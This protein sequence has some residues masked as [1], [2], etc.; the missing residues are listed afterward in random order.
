MFE[1]QVGR[2][3]ND[4]AG[5]TIE[6]DQGRNGGDLIDGRDHNR[7]PAEVVGPSSEHGACSQIAPGKARFRAKN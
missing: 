4:A 3:E 6:F 5:S 1:R 2:V 7:T